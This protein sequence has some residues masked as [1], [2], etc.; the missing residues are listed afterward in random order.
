ML[1]PG[2]VESHSHPAMAGLVVLERDLFRT[3][4]HGIHAVRVDLTMSAGRI[5]FRREDAGF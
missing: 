5:V 2:F 3:P 1:L 4:P